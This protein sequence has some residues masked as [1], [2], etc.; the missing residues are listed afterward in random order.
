VGKRLLSLKGQYGWGGISRL[1]TNDSG[2]RRFTKLENVYVSHD[3]SELRHF[4]GFGTFI[5][6]ND[7]NNPSG[8]ASYA[9]DAYRAV[10][11]FESP[12]DPY[13]LNSEYSALSSQSLY[14][15]A[16]MSGLF[17][18]EQIG[19][20][21]FVIGESRF[22]ED[23]IYD[24]SRTK[25]TIASIDIG[26]GTRYVLT[27]SGTPAAGSSF[28]ST[29]PGMNGIWVGMPVFIDEF[30]A[31]S[32]TDADAALIASDL[33][34]K[35]HEV[36]GF[37][38][39]TITL[40]TIGTG[41]LSAAVSGAGEMHRVRP[42]RN[43]NYSNVG[44]LPYSATYDDRPD[45]PDALTV[46]RVT[47]EIDMLNVATSNAYPCYPSWVAN[48]TRDFGDTIATD[49]VEGVLIHGDV[50]SPVRGASRREQ[51]R[52]PYRPCVE[53]ALDRII[54][55]A[56]GYGCMLQIPARTPIDASDWTSGGT[57]TS[58]IV[59]ENNSIYDKPRALG[60]PK[61]RLV[62]TVGTAPQDSPG[63]LGSP[64]DGFSGCVHADFG[65]PEH[66]LAAGAYKV[67]ISWED[68]G[69]GDEGVASEPINVT[70]PSHAGG[71]YAY[72]IRLN[73]LHPGYFM[74]ESAGYRMNVYIAPP[75]SEALA[76]YGSYDCWG[77][78]MSTLSAY[79]EVY[80]S[81]KYGFNICESTDWNALIRSFDLPVRGGDGGDISGV[82]DPTRLAPQSATM[83][84]GADA[85]KFIRGVLFS[86]GAVGDSGP[87]LQLWSAGASAQYAPSDPLF[88][89]DEFFIFSHSIAGA[90]VPNLVIPT[91]GDTQSVTLG[92]A[93]RSFPDA[94][95]GIGM[96]E[97]DLFPGHNSNLYVDRVLNPIV[98]DL[99]RLVSVPS[100]TDIRQNIERVRLTRPL[101]DRG[102][103]VGLSPDSEPQYSVF[104][105]DLFYVMPRGVLQIGDPGY[106]NRA[107]PLFRKIVDPPRGD[108]I[109]AIGQLAGSAVVCTQKETYS[110]SWYRNPGGETP[111]LVSS[112]FG[113]IGSN[114]MVEFDGGLA[115]L[116]DRGPVALGQG[117]QHVGRHVAEDFNG[118]DRRYARDTTGL[119]RHSWSAH[120][121]QRG[122]VM[123]G[124]LRSTTYGGTVRIMYE[125]APYTQATAS[126]QVL[127]RFPCD[128]V[129]IWSYRADAFSTW[130][131]PAGLE[132]YWMREMR[133]KYGTV[134]MC[135]LAADGRIYALDD[136]WSDSNGMFG[137]A[138]IV[139]VASSSATASTT[140]SLTGLVTYKDGDAYTLKRNFATLL[141][142]GMLVE[143]L[144]D[145]GDVFAETAI[146]SI[147][148]TSEDSNSESVIELSA[149]QTWSAG[150]SVRIGGRQR[151]TI[152]STYIG[153]ETP[154][155]MQCQRVQMRYSV[156]GTNGHANARV[157]M[158]KSEV[159]VGEGEEAR[160]V[161]FTSAGKWEAIGYQKPSVAIPLEIER[162]G[163]RKN[164]SRG[165]ISGP[166]LAVQIE[167]TGEKQT[168][169]HDIALEIG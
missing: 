130:R 155:T 140:L 152:T 56:P 45:D 47:D 142:V 40:T 69:T 66:G 43:N 48:R 98:R 58:G 4:P 151:A 25:L 53:P 39:A 57:S 121:P 166:E 13:P 10:V 109:R 168:R 44:T 96:V 160:I 74:P 116:S 18:F 126:D 125:G 162:V 101:F 12:N 72:T 67:A 78:N 38:G 95:Q 159:G 113:C 165:E 55:A 145:R 30:A 42:N 161:D 22:R 158:F 108:D 129:L 144:D 6:L 34:G 123:W 52:L 5:D 26:L 103:K 64:A 51:R 2:Q 62:D 11:S 139:G 99:Y 135:F 119:M 21:I 27:M 75:G 79:G 49:A 31:S 110:Y 92:I 133:D 132:I 32:G 68:V 163:R 137:N 90:R 94:Y 36:F 128:E 115:W 112:E 59:I 77:R 154:D 97:S 76:F 88:R 20:E 105:K 73:Y 35:V 107:S 61:A 24:A 141:R 83:P 136:E 7:T 147:T 1:N 3:G 46:W 153:A 81:A 60:M 23:P 82:L 167:I 50:A 80:R 157:R 150:H 122:L 33:T 146:S 89:D 85:C 120:D 17:A 100:T 102:R 149:P 15:R 9:P 84:M 118:D 143:F 54:L 127:S 117:L 104:N 28:D 8:Y 19:N 91:D 111:N 86:G 70:I 29:G 114:T 138:S 41:S 131:P 87:A 124:L 14:S 106:P 164:F 134:R 169:I 93:G 156:E 148:T 16:K 71:A 63:E 65:L 37:A